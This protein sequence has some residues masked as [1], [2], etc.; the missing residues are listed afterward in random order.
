MEDMPMV[1]F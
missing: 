1:T